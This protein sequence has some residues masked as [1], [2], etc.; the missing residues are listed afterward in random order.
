MT[1]M[2]LPVWFPLLQERLQEFYVMPPNGPGKVRLEIQTPEQDWGFIVSMGESQL[3][4]TVLALLKENSMG[5]RGFE[6]VALFLV[7]SCLI[8]HKDFS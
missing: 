2:A 8:C 6:R 1:V 3:D 4:I 5:E 7:Q